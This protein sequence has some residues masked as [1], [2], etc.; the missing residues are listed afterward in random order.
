MENTAKKNT[1]IDTADTANAVIDTAIEVVSNVPAVPAVPAEELQARWL[2][3]VRK[4][5]GIRSSRSLAT[6]E[7]AVKQFISYAGERGLQVL[8]ATDDDIFA[9]REYLR[10]SKSASTVQLYFG[11]VKMFYKFLLHEGKIRVNPAA[12]M[13]SGVKLNRDHKRD[14]L[15]QDSARQMLASMPRDT[16]KDKRNIAITALMTCTGLRCNE[17]A[18]A[19]V[20]DLQSV[21]G[22]PVLFIQGK[23]HD[24]KDSYVKLPSQVLALIE[25]YLQ[26]RFGNER[27]RD[28]DAL[29][30]STARNR[31][32]DTDDFMSTV[33]IRSIVKDAMRLIGFNDNRH[34]AHSL[35]HTCATLGLRAGKDITEVQQLLRHQNIQTTLIY[36]HALERE[37]NDT[38]LAI[39]DSIFGEG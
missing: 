14:Y 34:T 1:A 25:D 35:R 13:V 11:A 39:A 27:R 23:G 7:N 24:N 28:T 30:V 5:S 20:G 36:S 37:K 17:V 31:R 38:E 9:Y 32:A 18:T 12:N 26:A 3:Y 29:F 15:N 6:Y 16:I 33:S 2:D 19:T 4:H 22:A 10:G 21:G 8:Q